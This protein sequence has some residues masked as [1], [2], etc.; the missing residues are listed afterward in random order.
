MAAFVVDASAALPWCFG[1]EAT[2]W[3]KAL[4][5]RVRG[6]DQILVPA[7]WI[8]EVANALL[9]ACRKQRI[10]R[11]DAIDFLDDLSDL[12]IEIDPTPD[13]VRAK[14]VVSIAEKHRITAYDAAYLELAF[15]RKLPLAT[16]DADLRRSGLADGLPLL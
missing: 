4:L 6:G 14:D 13:Y 10:S 5:S 3:T 16:L 15:R 2:D 12:P 1:D 11:Q 9:F 8:I 7:H